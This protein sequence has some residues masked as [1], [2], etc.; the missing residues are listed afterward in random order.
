MRWWRTART[1]YALWS[2]ARVGVTWR[3]KWLAFL[4][5]GL[6]S[7]GEHRGAGAKLV[8]QPN[9]CLRS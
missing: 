1:V 6:V 7:M 2:R 4:L 3:D 9:Q 5:A 8:F